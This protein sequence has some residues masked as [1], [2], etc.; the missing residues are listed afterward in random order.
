MVVEEAVGTII[1]AIG[2][3]AVLYVLY[4]VFVLVMLRYQH[5]KQ[6]KQFEDMSLLVKALLLELQAGNEVRVAVTANQVDIHK[7]LG[8]MHDTLK[9]LLPPL[10]PPKTLKKKT[11]K[12]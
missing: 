8:E 3:V 2:G 11:G 7:K 1:K 12:K 10:N 6:K 9:A 5:K 4:G